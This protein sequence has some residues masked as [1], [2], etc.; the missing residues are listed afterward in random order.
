MTAHETVFVLKKKKR[1]FGK[2]VKRFIVEVKRDK[3][4]I[5]LV[6]PA[7]LCFFFFN[8]LPLSGLWMAF[9]NFKIKDGIFG[10]EFVGLKWF[11]QFFQ[12]PFFF[13]LIRN[14]FV[15]NIYALL[16][17]FW[18]PIVFAL[19]LNEVKN[20]LFKRTIQSISYF[21][22]FIS[23]VIVVGILYNMLSYNDGIVNS[24][25]EYFGLE[26]L[27]YVKDAKFFRTNL[28][29]SGIWSSFGFSAIIYM[30]ALSAID[31]QLYEAATVDGASRLRRIWHITL[32]G[33]MPIAVTLLIMSVGSLLSLGFEKI[34]LM[35]D[36]VNYEV[37]DVI[38]TY[39]YRRGLEGMEYSYAT[40]VG[41]FNSVVALVLITIANQIAKK[42]VN[43]RLF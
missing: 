33:I 23:V 1:S 29:G 31:P 30:G 10:S 13:R 20:K 41:F 24:I 7:L 43:V 6:V 8:I 17:G 21:P 9:T 40:A 36:P 34:I 27:Q 19:M 5:L 37:S 2:A 35:Y 25:R 12:N 11:I 22:Y 16:W 42:T 26:R 18:I 14:T 39:V 32:P 3:L 4:L 38:S 28:I 15:I